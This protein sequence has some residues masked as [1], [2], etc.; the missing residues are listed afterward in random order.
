V[1]RNNLG[2]AWIDDLA[3]EA[4]I[5]GRIGYRGGIGCRGAVRR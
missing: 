4:A 3:Q 1:S 2:L 5:L